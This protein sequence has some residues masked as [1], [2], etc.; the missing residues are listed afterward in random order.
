ML[1]DRGIEPTVVEYLKQ[2]L[3]ER[4]IRRLLK[5][6]GIS[7]RE[8]LRKKEAV[9]S[10]LGLDAPKL[11]H[12]NLIKF[13]ADHPVLIERPIAMSGDKAVVCRPPEQVHDIL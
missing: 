4:Q 5:M 13:M 1:R 6:L 3:N 12:D 7:P 10:A 8:L 9:Y 2:P 11:T